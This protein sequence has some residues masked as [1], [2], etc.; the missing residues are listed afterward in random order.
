MP[1]P[2][3]CMKMTAF[4]FI[5]HSSAVLVKKSNEMFPCSDWIRP[6][7]DVKILGLKGLVFE[8]NFGSNMKNWVFPPYLHGIELISS[9]VILQIA[10]S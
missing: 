8:T 9:S 5:E 1:N 2:L 10:V 6:Y 7:A 3:F 4:L